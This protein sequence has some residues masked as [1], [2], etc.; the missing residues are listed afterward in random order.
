[1]MG[2]YH[3]VYNTTRQASNISSNCCH[4]PGQQA[5]PLT[6]K[7]LE[8]TVNAS[9]AQDGLGTMMTRTHGNSFLVQR[10]SAIFGAN[11]IDNKREHAGMAMCTRSQFRY[12]EIT[13]C[14]WKTCRSAISGIGYRG[15]G[16]A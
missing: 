16:K 9:A 13:T 6:G 7:V 5:C 2:L 4:T 8:R 3:K 12:K 1:M 15:K 14:L 10:R 11:V